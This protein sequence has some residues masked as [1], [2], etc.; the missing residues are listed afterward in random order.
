[1]SID[2]VPIVRCAAS[3]C[4]LRVP[5]A[6][7]VCLICAQYISVT[8]SNNKFPSQRAYICIAFKY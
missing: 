8:Y 4:W 3:V 6:T 2:G 5:V 1:M 7:S